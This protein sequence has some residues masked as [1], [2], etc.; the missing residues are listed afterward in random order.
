MSYEGEAKRVLSIFR[1]GPWS[2]FLCVRRSVLP[3]NPMFKPTV[4]L[5]T[6]KSNLKCNDLFVPIVSVC[7]L[8]MTNA[9]SPWWNDCWGNGQ[10]SPPERCVQPWVRA[11]RGNWSGVASHTG[12]GESP[13]VLGQRG[14]GQYKEVG[15]WSRICGH[16]WKHQ[17]RR[18]GWTSLQ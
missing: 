14:P 7:P 1:A 16:Q 4:S 8:E 5:W 6:Q 15:V 12:K 18:P 13:G 11:E 2:S 9:W 3:G 17:H 10:P